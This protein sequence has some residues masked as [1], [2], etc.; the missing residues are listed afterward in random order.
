M[1]GRD[2]LAR[3]GL[4][5]ALLCGVLAGC[6]D[7]SRVHYQR[8]PDG[9]VKQAT[10]MTPM[11]SGGWMANGPFTT[12][13][14][15]GKLEQEGEFLKG[16]YHGRLRHWAENGQ[17]QLDSQWENGRLVGTPQAW[18]EA[19]KPIDPEL[20]LKGRGGTQAKQPH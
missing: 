17:L 11:S 1:R 14:P 4:G 19:G 2:G 10:R 8:W 5:V 16:S 9:T 7:G 3:R 15:S 12:Y 6:G 18:D 13:Y 20:V